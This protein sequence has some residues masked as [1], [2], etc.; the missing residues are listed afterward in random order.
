MFGLKF[1]KP[2]C[3]KKYICID[4]EGFNRITYR[5]KIDPVKEIFFTG[6]FVCMIFVMIDALLIK[7]DISIGYYWLFMSC[8]MIIRLFMITENDKTSESEEQ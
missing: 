4:E 6:F 1:K 5:R 3:V 7:V 2:Y 8:T